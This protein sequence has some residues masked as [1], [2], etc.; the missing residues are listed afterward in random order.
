MLL[1]SAPFL[2]FVTMFVGAIYMGV[3]GVRSWFRHRR[4]LRS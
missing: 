3:F 2:V 1:G 4:G